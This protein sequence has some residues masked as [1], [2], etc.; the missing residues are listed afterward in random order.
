MTTRPEER[1][2]QDF[3]RILGDDYGYRKSQLETE[4][5]IPRGSKSRD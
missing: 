3:L 5:P 2:R 1:V 4:F